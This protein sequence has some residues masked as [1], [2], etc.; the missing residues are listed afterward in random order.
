[1][2]YPTNSES[3]NRQET[4]MSNDNDKTYRY[5]GF[6]QAMRKAKELGWDGPT[7]E[8]LYDNGAGPHPDYKLYCEHDALLFILSK[9][10][11]VLGEH[12]ARRCE[13]NPMIVWPEGLAEL[14]LKTGDIEASCQQV[15]AGGAE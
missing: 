10:I 12:D 15:N 5:N 14:V 7:Y 9:G 2:S 3:I 11:Q 6:R 1:M 8:S 4:D 13:S